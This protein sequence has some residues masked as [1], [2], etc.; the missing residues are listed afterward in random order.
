[1]WVTADGVAHTVAL[2]SPSELLTER[3]LVAFENLRKGL[4]DEPLEELLEDEES[5]IFEDT[6]TQDT[7]GRFVGLTPPRAIL[8]GDLSTADLLVATVRAV[9]QRWRLDVVL[10]L[11]DLIDLE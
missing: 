11:Q 8:D 9:D 10:A 3:A 7:D 2:P 1:M 6:L 4:G 5:A